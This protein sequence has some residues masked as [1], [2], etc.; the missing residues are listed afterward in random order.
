MNKKERFIEKAKKIHSDKYDYS[1]VEY[2]NCKEKVC[3]ICPIHGEFWQTPTGHIDKKAECPKCK[4]NHR[5]TTEEFLNSIDKDIR[6]KYD[7][8]KFIYKKTHDKSVVICPKHGEF[9]QSPHNIRKGIGCPKCKESKLEMEVMNFLEKNNITYIYEYKF[10]KNNKKQSL[11][12]FLSEYNIGIECQGIQHFKPVDF[13]GKGEKW[14]LNEYKHIIELD[15]SKRK[16]CKENGIK[17][18]Y[19]TDKKEEVKNFE[20]SCFLNK[21]D[22]ILN[23]L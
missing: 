7:F 5:Y 10:S 8:S 18:F 17:L 19:Y 15:E 21:I 11:D 6:S 2:N 16:E 1:K 22:D 23:Y 14:A 4:G 9:L 13:A 20:V 12:F 3:I